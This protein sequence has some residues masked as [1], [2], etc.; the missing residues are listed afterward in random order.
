MTGSYVTQQ[1]RLLHRSCA[2]AS[3]DECQATH[4]RY[5]HCSLHQ[6]PHT[7]AGTHPPIYQF[8]N[9]CMMATVLNCPFII[10]PGHKIQ[11][12]GHHFFQAYFTYW[13]DNSSKYNEYDQQLRQFSILFP[14]A[15]GQQLSYETVISGLSTP[16][17]SPLVLTYLHFKT[18]EYT[19]LV[20]LCCF[21]S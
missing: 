16:L 7:A 10:L 20:A 19:N 9:A 4:V 11:H 5:R 21:I 18:L 1:T 6:N 14:H 8:I 2:S 15:R 3:S 12:S 13:R 17:P